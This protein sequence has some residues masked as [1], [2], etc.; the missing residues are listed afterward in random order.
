M[1]KNPW[2]KARELHAI[3]AAVHPDL[4]SLEDP[5]PFKIGLSNDVAALYPDIDMH[6][7]GRLFSWLTCRRAYLKA[8]VPGAPRYGLDGPSGEVTENQSKYAEGLFRY[9]ER[10][11]KPLSADRSAA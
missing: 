10:T 11:S 5:R 3:L 4:F 1:S 6:A 9:R 8:C 2:A 7:L